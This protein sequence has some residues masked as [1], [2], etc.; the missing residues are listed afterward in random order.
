M[1]VTTTA[2]LPEDTE[3]DETELERDAR[4]TALHIRWG[5]AIQMMLAAVPVP[6]FFA[7]RYFRLVARMKG[8]PSGHSFI[9][10][11]L[12]FSAAIFALSSWAMWVVFTPSE[13][14]Q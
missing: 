11:V 9:C 10:A 4:S 1:T 6:W 5:L 12:L 2:S 3:G 7:L 14:P 8:V 13:P